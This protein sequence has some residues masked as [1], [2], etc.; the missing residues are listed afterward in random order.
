MGTDVQKTHQS[1]VAGTGDRIEHGSDRG[2]GA[3]RKNVPLNEIH[4]T[5][6]LFV[7][8][9][10]NGDRLQQ[11]QAVVIEQA[12][13]LAEIVVVEL[14]TDGL[15]HFDRHQLVVAAGEVAIILQ[16]HG[17]P[18]RQSRLLDA[19]PGKVELLTGY[20]G[21]RHATA[22]MPCGMHRHA[23]PA[24]ADFQQVIR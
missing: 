13:A 21:A 19:L 5:P 16:Q 18:V 10:C 17:D 1:H 7:A 9:V 24:G 2:Y 20:G 8:L 22:V 6:R 23:T 3:A 11:H 12:P 4:R 14:V 15:D